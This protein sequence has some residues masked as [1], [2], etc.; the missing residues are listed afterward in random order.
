M[1]PGDNLTELAGVS[2]GVYIICYKNKDGIKLGFERLI[3][4]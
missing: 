3:V 1:K 2:K 4:Y